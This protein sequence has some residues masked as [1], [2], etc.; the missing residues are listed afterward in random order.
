M[1]SQTQPLVK[2]VAVR[3]TALADVLLAADA[4]LVDRVRDQRLATLKVSTESSN[5]DTGA[6]TMTK[7]KSALFTGVVAI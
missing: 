3:A 6:R 5:V 1:A 2:G 4:A 7:A